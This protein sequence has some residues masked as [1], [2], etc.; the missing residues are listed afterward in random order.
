MKHC[1]TQIISCERPRNYFMQEG[2]ALYAN[3]DPRGPGA[4]IL[5][6]GEHP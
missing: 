4:S 3:T 6:R 1:L 5:P 2:V